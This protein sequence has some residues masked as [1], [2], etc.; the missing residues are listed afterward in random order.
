[1]LNIIDFVKDFSLNAVNQVRGDTP[2]IYRRYR[3]W[4][5]PLMTGIMG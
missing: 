2:S 5:D 3:E 4:L 1:M